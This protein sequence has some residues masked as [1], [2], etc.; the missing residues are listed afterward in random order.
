MSNHEETRAHWKQHIAQYRASGLTQAAYARRHNLNQKL[1]SRW[2]RRF[3]EDFNLH[4]L[5]K[6]T[7]RAANPS[8]H[9]GADATA[10]QWLAVVTEDEEEADNV[11]GVPKGNGGITLRVDNV[12]IGV[13]SGFDETLLADVIRVVKSSC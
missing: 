1:V 2:N 12:T 10:P 4:P 9:Q 13:C 7:R 8:T 11:P 3:D 5:R 6:S